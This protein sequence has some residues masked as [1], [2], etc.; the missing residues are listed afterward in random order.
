MFIINKDAFNRC[1]VHSL[2]CNVLIFSEI[3]KTHQY[4]EKIQN[5]QQNVYFI[6]IVN[7]FLKNYKIAQLFIN[8]SESSH[9]FI[10]DVMMYSIQ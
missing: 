8:E 9:N 10:I 3:F 4:F 6:Y 7:I 5:I 1:D 2:D